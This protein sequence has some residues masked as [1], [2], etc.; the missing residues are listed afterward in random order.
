MK[1]IDCKAIAAEILNAETVEKLKGKVLVAIIKEV[2]DA[3]LSYL[4]AIRRQANKYG[5][6][7]REL[8]WSGRGCTG[9]A[10]DKWLA[11]YFGAFT[12]NTG[13]LLFVGFKPEDV[14][15]MVAESHTVGPWQ[16]L[17][18][19]GCPDVIQA[20][21]TVLRRTL[22]AKYCGPLSTVI[23]G[24][25]EL[26]TKAGWHLLHHGHTVTFCHT[27]T[28]DLDSYCRHAD[29]IVSFAGCPE[30]IHSGMVKDG[31][32]I[33]SVGCGFKDGKLCGDIDLD[34]MAARDVQVTATP[35]GVGVVTTALLFA[36]LAG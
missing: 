32:V 11:Q 25:S 19:P 18:R 13:R 10:L 26:A 7:L 31:A 14:E 27:G 36:S 23:I 28:D 24:R 3:N 8:A 20:A 17:D 34:S 6:Q 16:V 30:L 5:V 2:N 1:V 29:A 22:G 9:Y 12:P 15:R 4:K 21:D 33:V 35:G